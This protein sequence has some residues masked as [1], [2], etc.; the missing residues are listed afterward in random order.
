MGW[1]RASIIEFMSINMWLLTVIAFGF[2]SLWLN[3]R[4]LQKMAIRAEDL[5]EVWIFL[6]NLLSLGN[7]LRKNLMDIV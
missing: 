2:L 4:F 5:K 3:I 7:F 6:N 1:I